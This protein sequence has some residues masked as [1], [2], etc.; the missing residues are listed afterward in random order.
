MWLLLGACTGPNP[1][2]TVEEPWAAVDVLV[3]GAGPAGLRAAAIA[4]RAGADVLVLERDTVVGGSA[5]YGEPGLLFAGTPVQEEAGVEDS[6]EALLADWPLF[7]GGDPTA[8]WTITYAERGI[9]VFESLSALGLDFGLRDSASPDAGGVRRL[10][11]VL[12]PDLVAALGAEVDADCILLETEATEL[13]SDDDRVIGARFADLNDGETGWIRADATIVATG[14]FLRDLDRVRG[15]RPELQDLSLSFA[16]GAQADGGGLSMLEGLDADS[17]NLDVMALFSHGVPD[18]RDP[19][20]ELIVSI[21]RQVP[22]INSDGERFVAETA[23][24][25][26]STAEL[27]MEQPGATAWM[28]LDEAAWD[29]LTLDDPMEIEAEGAAPE[30]ADYLD[31]DWL[32]EGDTLDEIADALG[33]TVEQLEATVSQ[34]NAS[35]A[36]DTDPFRDTMNGALPVEQPP[37]RVMRI[38][39]SVAKSF[40]GVRIDERGRVLDVDGEVVEGVWAAGELSGMIGGSIVE[41]Q[42][43]TGSMSGVILGAEIAA[44]DAAAQ[45]LAR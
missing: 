3:I 7:T 32:S 29:E 30:I 11:Y 24:N 16:T 36:G 33:C 5:R 9:E 17:V 6:A 44:E 42:G 18:I 8:P 37:Y 15:V 41:D 45:S 23:S 39:I 38:A 31:S 10:H 14:G 13:V 28:L 34:W 26:F 4:Q 25:E 1:D 21:L 12:G 43:W 27:V 40:G 19:A 2:P 22:W 35:V 20:E